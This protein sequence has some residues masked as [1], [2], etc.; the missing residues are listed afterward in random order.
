MAILKSHKRKTSCSRLVSVANQIINRTSNDAV[1]GIEKTVKWM[2]TDHINSREVT[3]LMEA[4]QRC[5]YWHAYLRRIDRRQ[6]VLLKVIQQIDS[7]KI[8]TRFD[9]L[10]R[11]FVDH[12]LF[13]L[14]VLWGYINPMLMLVLTTLLSIVLGLI[15]TAIL[16]Y[17]LFKLLFS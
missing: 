2:V 14:D 16:I 3:N 17:V 15:F 1:K 10:M 8:P 12:L 5:N 13:I 7:G 9:D 11:W 6:R 4:I